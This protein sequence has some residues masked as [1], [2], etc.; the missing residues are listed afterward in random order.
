MAGLFKLLQRAWGPL[1][2]LPS[3]AGP[4]IECHNLVI[5]NIILKQESK[6]DQTPWS[7]VK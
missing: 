2:P 1:G 6:T 7:T 4:F 5:N 3:Q